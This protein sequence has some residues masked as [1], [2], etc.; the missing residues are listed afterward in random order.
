[1][2]RDSLVRGGRG[3]FWPYGTAEGCDLLTLILKIK[4]KLSQTSAAPIEL[5]NLASS[6]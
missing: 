4:V 5:V 1:M 3:F 2:D 6:E